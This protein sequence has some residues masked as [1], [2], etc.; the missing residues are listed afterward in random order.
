MRA[1]IFNEPFSITTGTR[2]DPSIVE[3]TDAVVRVVL[4]CV[5]GSDLWYFR[6]DSPFQPGP[7]G[8]ELIGVVEDVGSAVRGVA[9]GDL[10][11]CP[12]VLRS[13]AKMQG[14]K[15]RAHW[16]HLV[17]HGSLHLIGYDHEEAAD[18]PRM[19]RREVRVLR[20]L[21]FGNPYRSA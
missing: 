7:I 5:C 12:D 11:I 16:A 18:A 2:R 4:A 13:E 3:P 10:V 14:K 15:L 21:G 20:K 17:V 19:E 1:A 9:K 6:G 8:H